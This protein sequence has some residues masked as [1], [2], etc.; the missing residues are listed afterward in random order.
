ML[1]ESKFKLKQSMLTTIGQNIEIT[2]KIHE[3]TNSGAVTTVASD[4]LFKTMRSGVIP[5][6]SYFKEQLRDKGVEERF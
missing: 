4:A 3:V 6:L 5:D 1:A 2:K